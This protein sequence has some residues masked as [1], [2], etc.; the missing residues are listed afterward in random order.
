MTRT[1]RHILICVCIPH[2]YMNQYHTKITNKICIQTYLHIYGYTYE[3]MR[4]HT[5]RYKHV[6]AQKKRYEDRA[7]S[8]GNRSRVG[9]GIVFSR[10]LTAVV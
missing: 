6:C 8:V 9:Y 1:H 4:K 3:Y 2:A 5:I 10:G 7:V